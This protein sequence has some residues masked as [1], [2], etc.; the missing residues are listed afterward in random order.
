MCILL[1]HL[2]CFE[3]CIDIGFG[4][5]EVPLKKNLLVKLLFYFFAMQASMSTSLI[6]IKLDENQEKDRMAKKYKK[7][8]LQND[9][10]P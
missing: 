10:N 2:Q 6:F 9:Q 3:H 5:L 8:L 4:T 1:V 7:V